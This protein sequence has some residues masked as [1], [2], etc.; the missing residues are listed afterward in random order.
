MRK[1]FVQPFKSE[2][3]LIKT[4]QIFSVEECTTKR[5]QSGRGS[6]TMEMEAVGCWPDKRG[7][8]PRERR[9]WWA[10]HAP[11]KGH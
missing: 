3:K 11:G 6:T 1:Q 9:R 2:T 8:R 7:C 4:I 10:E 5:A